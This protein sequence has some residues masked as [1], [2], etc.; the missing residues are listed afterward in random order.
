MLKE[1]KRDMTISTVNV[2]C[3]LEPNND[4]EIKNCY[5]YK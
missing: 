4:A 2:C 5:T 3:N 1:T